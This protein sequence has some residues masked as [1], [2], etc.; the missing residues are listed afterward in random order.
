MTLEQIRFINRISGPLI[1]LIVVVFSAAFLA[2]TLEAAPI[3]PNSRQPINT[4]RGVVLDEN[5]PVSGATVRVQLTN[6]HVLSAEDG[7]FTLVDIN[8]SQVLTL[9]A[10]ATGHYIG[11]ARVTP[12]VGPVVITTYQHFTT[13]NVDYDWF[14]FEGIKG[15]Q[16]C[17]LC[18]V[19]YDEWQQDIHSQ[20]ATN[21]RFLT[22]YAGTDVNGNQS[23]FTKYDLKSGKPVLPDLHEPYFGPGYRLDNPSRPG[24]CASCHTPMAAKIPTNNG[25][26]W[27][28]C[29]TSYTAEVS[30]LIPM[31][32]SPTRL[33]GNAAEGISCEFCHKISD[34][35][36]NRKTGLPY[37]DSPGI[38]SL[39]LLRP[40]E[41]HDIFFGSRDDVVRTDLK[42]P[43]DSYL[44]LQKESVFCASCHYGVMG[45]V[46]ASMKVTG[47]VLVYSSFKEWLESKYNSE[48]DGK[49]CQDCHMP[50]GLTQYVAFPEKGGP[51]RDP[52]SIHSHKMLGAYDEAFMQN[53]V[54]MTSTAAIE[55][56]K[57]VVDINIVNDQAGHDVPTDSAMRHIMLV[58]KAT[59][60][61]G[62]SLELHNGTKLPA[63]AGNYADD[64]GKIF[65]KVLKDEATGESPTGAIWRPVSV[66]S[67]TR[68]KPFVPDTSQYLFDVAGDDAITVDVQLV[69]RYAPQELMEQKG[70]PDQD[71]MMKHVT[72]QVPKP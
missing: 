38:M 67:D 24:V 56:G 36:I 45:G 2:H 26:G 29:H 50:T 11:W 46:V 30:E 9:T 4:I 70:W 10:W 58:I 43:R 28:G 8:S 49:T 22:M 18:H 35:Q 54:S 48:E 40:P 60:A 19:A 55:N 6:N 44:P 41:G 51:P 59:D 37:E 68:L 63:W 15:S 62:K 42:T 57:L 13:D 5:G 21:Y 61:T 25:C 3:P 53:A 47:G 17:G 27:S 39:K 23:P 64:P 33:T 20:T 52:N 65:A 7:T 12:G 69:Y 32:A 66:V 14:E 31:G 1:A 71:I 72:I 16:A 34:V